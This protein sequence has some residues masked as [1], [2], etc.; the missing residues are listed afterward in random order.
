MDR[1]NVLIELFE[2]AKALLLDEELF[3][4]R[5]ITGDSVESFAEG[6]ELSRL[7]HF[8]EMMLK[9]MTVIDICEQKR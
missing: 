4:W 8:I 2:I 7:F 9:V 6:R 3:P 5:D 1:V